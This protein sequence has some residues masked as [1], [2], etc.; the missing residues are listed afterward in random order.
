MKRIAIITG[1]RAE[2]GLLRRTM[3]LLAN[4]DAI[5]LDVYVTGMHL[6]PT[7]GNTIDEIRSDGFDIAFTIDMN[8]DTNSQCSMSKSLGIGVMG[9]SDAFQ[10]RDPDLLLVLGDRSEPFAA[11]IAASHMNLPVAHIA[12]GQISGGAVIDSQ[13]RHAITKLS[14]LHFVTTEA[15]AQRVE[16]LG[17]EG[18]RIVPVGAP[19]VDD[20]YHGQYT[21]ASEIY[22]KY[23]LPRDRPIVIV[24]QHPET[25]KPDDSERQIRNTLNSVCA[26]DC[27]PFIIY[28]NSDLGSSDI[29]SILNSMESDINCSVHKN[30]NRQDFLGLMNISGAMV[31]NS[32]SGII[33]APSFG[34]PVVNVGDRQDGRQRAGNV[35]DVAHTEAEITEALK[36]ALFDEAVRERAEENENPYFLGGSAERIHSELRDVTIDQKLLEK[37]TVL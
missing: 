9:F 35:I 5:D 7:H 33:E 13:V 30:I 6:S 31:G 27:Y 12:G 8:L 32:S 28:P 11:A 26:V 14:H 34:L 3:R 23:D 2:Y 17:E 25:S 4:D 19:G 18:W 22:E 10:N 1:T 29:I 20:I 21:P 37:K 15:N 24:L 16:A 36:S